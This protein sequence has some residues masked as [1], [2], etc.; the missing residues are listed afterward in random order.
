MANYSV[1]MNSDPAQHYLRDKEAIDSAIQGVLMQGSYVMGPEVPAFE[2]EF[3]AYC[4]AEYAVAVTSGTAS[5]LV[6]LLAA[7]VEP[8]DEV[9]GVANADMAISLAALHR[10]ADLK[11]VDIEPDTFNMDPENL[12]EMLSAKTR[13]VIV[14]DMYGLPANM[15]AIKDVL[16]DRPDV[17]LIEDASLATGAEYG[18]TKTGGLADI[19]CFSLASGKVLGVIGSGGALTTN[20]FDY[21]EKINWVRHYGRSQSAYRYDDPLPPSSAPEGV[22]TLG[23][24]ERLDSIQAAVGRVKLARLDDDLRLRRAAAAV[25][26]E[27]LEDM[28]CNTPPVPHGSTHSYRVYVITVDP[29]IRD[30]FIRDMREAGIAA[31]AHYVPPDHLHPYF[32]E[33]GT[34]PGMLPVTERVADSLVCLPSHPY[35]GVDQVWY[36]A[37]MARKTLSNLT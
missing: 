31:G 13:A 14:A 2:A 21:Y 24:N 23:L 26:D 3:A 25:Y 19:G 29:G 1:S 36:A 33:R 35:M 20:S 5:L 18:G 6:A 9:L 10:G 8:G 16:A 17:V 12:R 37:E 32:L 7:G 28:P 27:V 4:D 11:W 22:V 34:G 15:N 30:A